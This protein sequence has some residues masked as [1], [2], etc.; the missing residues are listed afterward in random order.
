VS[1]Q[2]SGLEHLAERL[3]VPMLQRVSK[4]TRNLSMDASAFKCIMGRIK[5]FCT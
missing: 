1:V 5:I 4:V 2:G 3:L